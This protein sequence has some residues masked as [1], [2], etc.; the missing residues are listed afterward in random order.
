MRAPVLAALFPLAASLTLATR[1]SAE[2]VRE[3]F[4]PDPVEPAPGDA[5]LDLSAWDPPVER[6]YGWQTLLVVGAS[7]ALLVTSAALGILPLA[8]ASGVGS[9]LGGP[10]IHALHGE[11]GKAL[12]SAGM[13]L[14]FP[15]GGLLVG[16]LVG[17]VVEIAAGDCGACLPLSAA[18]G[19]GIGHVIAVAIDVDTLAFETL[20]PGSARR[21]PTFSLAPTL[22]LGPG[23]LGVG[24]SGR[25]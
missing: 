12:T 19:A 24:A 6:W 1:A 20:P 4:E 18:I 11:S 15:I 9:V 2:P 5:E 22:R 23:G 21:P 7:D 3:R 17:T 8:I 25:F 13:N 10:T 14:G 16:G